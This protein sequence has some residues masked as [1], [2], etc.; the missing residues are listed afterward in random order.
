MNIPGLTTGRRA[1]ADIEPR[2]VLRS[3][4]DD[5]T[6]RHA[7]GAASPLIGISTNVS[8]K[9]GKTADVVRSGLTP[10]EYGGTVPLDALLTADADGRAIAVSLPVG[11]DTYTIGFAEIAGSEGDWGSVNVVPGFIPAASND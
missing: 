1:V 4:D 3:G 8:A 7:N 2:R 6:C 5:G 9:V 10:V 11:E